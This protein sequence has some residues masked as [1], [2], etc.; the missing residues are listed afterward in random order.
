M[1]D[2]VELTLPAVKQHDSKCQHASVSIDVIS[3]DVISK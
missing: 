2:V 3:I 1:I